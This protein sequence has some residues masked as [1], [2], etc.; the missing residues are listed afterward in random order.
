MAQLTN[1]NNQPRSHVLQIL[2]LGPERCRS[3]LS[4][5]Y[6]YHYYY[7]YYYYHKVYHI[8]IIIITIIIIIIIIILTISTVLLQSP[9]C[10][11]SLVAD[12][13]GRH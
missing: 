13:W 12:K 4:H 7:Y 5:Y 9:E 2:D 3:L 8:I 1:H 6:Y 11:R 10:C